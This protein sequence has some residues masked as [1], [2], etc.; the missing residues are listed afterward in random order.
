VG[1]FGSA[2]GRDNRPTARELV[3]RRNSEP[4][5]S[6]KS[7]SIPSGRGIDGASSGT[8]P[9]TRASLATRVGHRPADRRRY[10][11]KPDLR[12]RSDRSW[13]RPDR[14]A[15]LATPRSC[16]SSQGSGLSH[17]ALRYS[18][19]RPPSTRKATMFPSAGRRISTF[20]HPHRTARR[21]VPGSIWDAMALGL[22]IT[23]PWSGP[24]PFERGSGHPGEDGA[25]LGR[26]DSGHRD[27]P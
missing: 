22:S 6:R 17:A 8:S 2:V 16:E 4:G 10:R 26:P 15:V 19:W 13:V 7:L 27:R 12:S 20:T 18:L 25:R 21:R 1:P 14:P 9:P 3:A 23:G 5:M 11:R 24:D